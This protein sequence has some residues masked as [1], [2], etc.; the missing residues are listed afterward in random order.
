MYTQPHR[1]SQSSSCSSASAASALAPY[2]TSSH[3]ARQRPAHDAFF[4]S[5][6][7]RHDCSRARAP[8]IAGG[9]PR[10]PVGLPCES[11]LAVVV[12]QRREA[13]PSAP[14][15]LEGGPRAKLAVADVFRRGDLAGAPRAAGPALA[16]GRVDDVRAEVV[17]GM[18]AGDAGRLVGLVLPRGVHRAAV[19]V[20]EVLEAV[21]GGLLHLEPA[22]VDHSLTDLIPW[23]VKADQPCAPPRLL[24]PLL[25]GAATA[26][27]LVRA[28]V[29]DRDGHGEEER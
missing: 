4:D 1:R 11:T 23:R 17:D 16:D 28:V 18:H 5:S 21:R 26:V 10:A 13:R 22:R 6:S 24:S 2:C 15:E 8:P 29:V 14:H 12:Q 19:D 20:V 9:S 7:T 27:S 3:A 25:R